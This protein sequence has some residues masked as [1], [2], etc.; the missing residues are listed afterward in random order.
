MTART[1]QIIGAV[2]TIIVLVGVIFVGWS[3]SA[4]KSTVTPPTIQLSPQQR[5]Q[6]LYQEGMADIAAGETTRA[7]NALSSAIE[8]DPTNSAAKTALQQVTNPQSSSGS[9][10]SGAKTPPATPPKTTPATTAADPFA[11]AKVADLATLL[12]KAYPGFG[13]GTPATAAG[14]AEVAGS[15]SGGGPISHAQ[16]AVYDRGSAADAATFVNKVSKTLYNKNVAVVTVNGAPAHYGTDGVRYATVSFARGRYVFEVVLTVPM[17][18]L[19]SAQAA[20]VQA[21]SSFADKP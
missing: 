17:S 19:K 10:G 13:L 2:A 7:I 21:A 14:D 18:S 3:L 4:P 15:P 11:N 16:W 12:P 20:A 6:G 8:I 9:D 5:S 1:K